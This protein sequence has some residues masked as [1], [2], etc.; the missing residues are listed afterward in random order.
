MAGV[1]V[2]CDR[3]RLVIIH[4]SRDD[5]YRYLSLTEERLPYVI[6]HLQAMVQ[7]SRAKAPNHDHFLLH[8]QYV[9]NG[10]LALFS[11]IHNPN[12]LSPPSNHSF[13]YLAFPLAL[14]AGCR[15]DCYLGRRT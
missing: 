1:L 2:T 11:L 13:P 15:L 3:V 8:C 9:H 12:S 7:T 14:V 6:V 5:G 10:R 4:K